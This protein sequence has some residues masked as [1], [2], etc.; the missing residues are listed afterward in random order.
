LAKQTVIVLDNP[1]LD[2]D[3]WAD[4]VFSRA[5]FPRVENEAVAKAMSQDAEA[6]P[7]LLQY[8]G[9]PVMH[10][11]QLAPHY[12][13]ALEKLHGMEARVG[14]YGTAWV[15]YTQP[16]DAVVID[17]SEVDKRA[18]APNAKDGSGEYFRQQ[19]EAFVRN[20]VKQHVAPDRVLELPLGLSPQDKV[21]KTLAFL[22][23]LG[24]VA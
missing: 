21:E 4:E 24:L 18:K 16:V 10:A 9:N 22:K 1:P 14:L 5:K 12:K 8:A 11:E 2:R 15:V 7:A 23:K 19:S 13:R 3:P 6:K 20:R 17:W